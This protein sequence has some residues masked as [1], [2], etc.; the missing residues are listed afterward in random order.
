MG[1]I[2]L[3]SKKKRN[4]VW[5]TKHDKRHIV[6]NRT[7]LILSQRFVV[8]FI[9]V[10]LW[11]SRKNHYGIGHMFYYGI[12]II[13]GGPMFTMYIPKKLYTIICF[14]FIKIISITLP[15]K[16]CPLEHGKCWLLT[17]IDLHD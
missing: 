16:P 8:F 5:L 7:R 9:V 17:N 13:C 11:Y 2:F 4:T 10:F 6:T 1:S 12:V 14:I 3:T 15:T